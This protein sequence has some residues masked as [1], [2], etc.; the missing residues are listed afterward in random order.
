VV[1][2]AAN[3]LDRQPLEV[4]LA[5]LFRR[6]A[7]ATAIVGARTAGQLRGALAALDLELPDELA[8]ALDEVS[9]PV[10]GYP[11]RF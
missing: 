6:P 4:A 10:L 3:G 5:W 1:A 11:E 7:V 8:T 2:I 9:A